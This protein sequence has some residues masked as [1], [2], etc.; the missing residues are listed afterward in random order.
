MSDSMTKSKTHTLHCQE[1]WFSLL[2]SG[3]KPVEGRKNSPKYQQI[4]A[5][6]FIK[7]H[8]GQESFLAQVIEVRHFASLEE[9][10]RGVTVEKALPG[11]TS[12]ED[13][14]RT[15][16]QWNTREEIEKEGFLGIFIRPC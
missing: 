6:D 15:Y 7:F 16:L 10:L 9:Y 14:V 11:I 8:V 5:G 13:A 2:K 4:K 12:F 1:P 3:K